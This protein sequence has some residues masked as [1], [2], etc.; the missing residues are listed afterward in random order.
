M[1]SKTM[2]ALLC[3][4]AVLVGQISAGPLPQQGTFCQNKEI[5]FSVNVKYSVFKAQSHKEY[6]FGFCAR[7]NNRQDQSDHAR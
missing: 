7:K 2:I 3:L 5:Y 1:T 4:L 6:D